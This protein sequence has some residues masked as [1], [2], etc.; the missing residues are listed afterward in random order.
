MTL[1]VRAPGNRPA[2]R[3]YVLDVV[4]SDWLGIEY[5]LTLEDRPD[6]RIGLAGDPDGPHLSMADVLLSVPDA[7]WLHERSLPARPLRR[8]RAV[9]AS[10]WGDVPVLSGRASGD[11]PVWDR[12]PDGIEVSVDLLGGI[13][14]LLTRYEEVVLR[15]RDMHDRFPAAATTAVADG[16]A[17]RPLADEYADQLW[18]AIQSLW[19]DLRRRPRTFR[20]RPTHDVDHVWSTLGSGIRPV[21][22]SLAADLVRRRDPGLALR[23]LRSVVDAASGRVDR[24][25]INTFDLL[26]ETSE[27]NGLRSTFYFMA[28]GSDPRFD[29]TYRIGD[30]RVAPLI[31]RIHDRGHE[32]GLHASYHTFRSPDRMVT[33]LDALR[34]VCR[35]L[36][37]DQETWG[38]RQHYLRFE[39]PGTWRIQDAARFAHDSTVGFAE[40][41]GFRSGTCREHDVFDLVERRAL[42]LRERPLIFMDAASDEF[43]GMD[44]DAAADRCRTLVAA[45]R[46]HDGDAVVL[47]H[48]SSLESARQQ[49]HYRELIDSLARTP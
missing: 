36:G 5:E 6:V 20:L 31:R 32:I 44:L 2:E 16:F 43:L 37:V 3:R 14:F 48:N 29:G 1:H 23:R 26:M 7:D 41:N 49:A 19:P 40:L 45:C 22:L 47:Y 15:S 24:D 34:D 17:D 4:L 21:V 13:F 9:G 39:A 33:E 38:V 18:A 8:V 27:R 46:R 11:G 25:P 10:T 30:P 35:G 28:G 42:R 12:R